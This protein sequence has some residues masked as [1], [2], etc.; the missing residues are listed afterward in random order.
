MDVEKVFIVGS[1]LMGSGIAQVCAQSGLEVDLYDVD[2]E[3]L[4]RALKSIEWS[5]GK[6]VEKG[7]LEEEKSIIMDRD[8][9]GRVV[10]RNH[11]RRPYP[12]GGRP[13]QGQTGADSG[14]I[15]TL[16]SFL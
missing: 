2:P 1:G 13:C 16:Q 6:F 14:I 9:V 15:S 8:R 3:A 11:P 10:R 7:A 5:V 4:K 12:A